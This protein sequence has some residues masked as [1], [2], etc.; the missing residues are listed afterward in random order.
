[1]NSI[2]LA[3]GLGWFSLGLGLVEV[4]APGRIARG[5]GLS[6][7]PALVGLFGM[8]EV[9]AGIAVLTYPS[10]PGPVWARVGGDL[11]DLAVLALHRGGRRRQERAVLATAAVL[12]VTALD[13]LCAAALTRRRDQAALTARRTRIG[14][15]AE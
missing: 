12:G 7:S 5:L 8:R 4:A 14:H 9:G 6:V 2:Q 3:K 1:M 13:V 15:T 10:S 11:L